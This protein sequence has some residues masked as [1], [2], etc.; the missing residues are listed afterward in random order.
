MIFK[1]K[2]K[3]KEKYLNAAE[4]DFSQFKNCLLSADGV[5]NIPAFDEDGNIIAHID[6]SAAFE[7]SKTSSNPIF[8]RPF[9]T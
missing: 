7:T 5:K 3:T 2:S 8:K 4:L 9:K 1:A 6:S